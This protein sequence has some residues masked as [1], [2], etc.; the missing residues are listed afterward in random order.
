M[1]VVIAKGRVRLLKACLASP[2]PLGHNASRLLMDSVDLSVAAPRRHLMMPVLGA[3]LRRVLDKLCP[4]A[5][6]LA[7][8]C[9]ARASVLA[10]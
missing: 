6:V 9:L 3:C 8:L 5:S 1:R 7:K 4:V 2:T 10:K